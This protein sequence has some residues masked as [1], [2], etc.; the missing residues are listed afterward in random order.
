[1]AGRTVQVS[2]EPNRIICIGPGTLRLIV[3]LDAQDK[4]AGVE[5]MEKRFAAGRPYWIA[6]PRLR[7]LPDIGPGGPAAINKKP[8][9]EAVL[10]IAPD[11]IFVTYMDAPLADDVSE[12]L[13]I[14]VVVLSYGELAVFDRTVYD[15]LE[16]AGAILG[17]RE[18]AAAVIKYIEGLRNDLDRRTADISDEAK[19]GVFV[20]GIGHR[21]THGIESTQREYIPLDWNHAVNLANRVEARTGSH[22]FVDKEVLLKLDPDVIFIDGGGLA[23]VAEDFRKKPDF[24]Q[25]LKAFRSRQVYTLLPFN[26]Y[27]TNIATAMANAYTIGKILYPSRFEDVEL[28]RQADAIYTFLVG[29]PVYTQ[30]RVEYGEL[31]RQ[32]SFIDFNP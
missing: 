4:V 28:T 2:A 15:S 29:Q 20:G 18:R 22:V 13:G 7:T 21:G 10:R 23:L 31:G 12:T 24:Y 6:Q 3:Y 11:L 30:M 14:P 5:S 19:P 32:P 17:R 25:A 16:L 26:F 9:M 8:D 27:T 1:M